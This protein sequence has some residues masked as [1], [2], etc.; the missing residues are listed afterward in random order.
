METLSRSGGDAPGQP[1]R[2]REIPYN[3]TSLSD[4]E[5]VIRLLGAAAWDVL[6]ALR[7]RVSMLVGAPARPHQTTRWKCR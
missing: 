5:I 7:L 2:L 4:R 1:A 3:Y 6:G